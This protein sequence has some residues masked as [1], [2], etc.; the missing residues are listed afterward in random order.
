MIP[1]IASIENLIAHD[2]AGRNIFGLLRTDDL[3]LAAQSLRNARRVVVVSGFY[4]P[5]AAASETDGPPGAKCL[6][7]ALERMGIEVIHLTDSFNAGVLVALGM[8][9]TVVDEPAGCGELET[10]DGRAGHRGRAAMKDWAARWL[11]RLAPTHLVSVERVGR[12]VDGRYRNMRGV[13]I[14][15]TTVPLD[16]LFIEAA[17]RGVTTIGIGDGGNEIGMGSVFAE[18]LASVARGPRIACAVA[19]DYCIAAGS[20]NWGGYGLVGALSVLARQDLLPSSSDVVEHIRAAVSVG[21]AV[22]GVT[23]LREYTV[24]GIPASASAR[25]VERI[26]SHVGPSPFASHPERPVGVMGFGVTGRA[27]VALLCRIG[28]RVRVSEESRE[29]I[30][31]D[32]ALEAVETGS[33][34]VEFLADCAFVVASPGV[35]T[36][37]PVV[38]ELQRR[39]IPV[40]SELELASHYCDR[41]LIAITGSVGKRTT[42]EL[43]ARFL[44]PRWRTIDTAGNRGTPLSAVLAAYAAVERDERVQDASPIIVAV[45]SFQLESVVHFRPRVAVLLN[46]HDAHLDRHGTTSE[47]V[48]T[49]SRIYMNQHADDVLILN[50]D[51]VQLRSLARKHRGRVLRLSSERPVDRGA[52][53]SD[54]CIRIRIDDEEHELGP[55]AFPYVEDLLAAVV[56]A[57]LHGVP[58]EQVRQLLGEVASM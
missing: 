42:V 14:T 41:P 31:T 3:R 33:H 34:A 5:E 23:L 48:R 54:G 56:V 38:A 9:P 11:D 40:I 29:P 17:A 26:R 10:P 49:K 35:S 39:G 4:I 52:W 21:G 27:A 32:L 57:R 1:R 8:S 47:Y 36:D 25:M 46:I 19:A 53:I 24:D 45:S 15:N 20:S 30:T 37:H 18:T 13:D 28:R 43:V 50:E 58:V 2:P 12:G 51:D 6:G 55:A 7:L 44:A 16:E 22:D